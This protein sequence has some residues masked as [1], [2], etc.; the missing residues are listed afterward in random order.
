M[1][2]TPE[3]TIN[4]TV[5]VSARAKRVNLHV[6][7][8]T[9]LEVVIPRRFDRS[10]IPGLLQENL[11]WIEKKLEKWS[12]LT[13]SEA[14]WPPDSLNLHA[15]DCC[16]RLVFLKSSGSGKIRTRLQ[17]DALL[18]SGDTENQ[19]RVIQ[20]VAAVL[21]EVA[22]PVLSKW[23]RE[24]S[25]QHALPYGRLTIRGQKTRWGSCSSSGNISLNYKL[26][27]LPSRAGAVCIAS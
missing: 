24:L 8:H 20:A 10:L 16:I 19:T 15:I 1:T 17:D 12:T 25:Q 14:S 26:L 21:K 27:F 23:L 5:R 22:K 13:S 2:E 3:K 6:K 11:T 18:L 4:Y 9:G 7:P